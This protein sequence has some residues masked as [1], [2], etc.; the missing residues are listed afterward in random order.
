[1]AVT[2]E[3]ISEY[4]AANPGLSDAEI[5]AAMAQHSVTPEQMAQVTG[6]GQDVVQARYDAATAPLSQIANT[7]GMGAQG[8]GLNLSGQSLA[9]D[10]GSLA[11]TAGM[12]IE[13]LYRTYAGRE[14]DPEGLAY[15]TKD[16]G[17]T[18]D[19][20]EIN[21]FQT[22]VAE[23]RAQGTEPAAGALTQADSAAVR[24]GDA[25]YYGDA[26]TS[27]AANSNIDLSSAAGSNQTVGLGALP[28]AVSGV[29]R[30]QVLAAYANNPLAELNPSEEAINYWLGQG[31]GSFDSTVDA[32]RAADPGLAAAIDASRA[33]SI[34]TGST[35]GTTADTTGSVGALTQV[36]GTDLTADAGSVFDTDTTAITDTTGTAATTGTT[37]STGLNNTHVIA[38]GDSTTFGYNA[39]NQLDT[40]MVSS[41]QTA[42]GNNYTIDNFGVNSTTV[43][44]L[45]TGENGTGSNWVNTLASDAG[46]VVLNYGMNEAYRGE[47]PATFAANLT[48]AVNDLKAAGKTVILQT[49]NIATGYDWAGNVSAYADVIRNVA[50][51]TGSAIDDKYATTSGMGDIFDSATGDTIHP[52]STAYAAL[53]E[54]LANVISG[55]NKTNTDSIDLGGII[56]AGDSFLSGDKAINDI[57]NQT[58][59]VVTNTAIGGQT[60]SDVLNQL[61]AFNS[62]GGTFAPGATVV[63]NVGGNDLLGGIDA[64]TV[65]NNINEIVSRLDA[66]GV[67]VV[68]S[69]APNVG[70]VADLTGSTNLA[71]SDIYNNIANSNSNVTLVDSMSGLLNQKNLV[72]ETGFHLTAP[73]QAGFNTSLSNAY[74]Q[75][76]GASPISF[77]DQNIID[78]VRDNNLTAD[79]AMAMAPSFS[80]DPARV[81]QL[82]AAS[83]A[84]DSDS[85]NLGGNT[86]EIANLY[87]EVL[88]RAPSA[89]EIENWYQQVG[90]N[91]SSDERT[92]F[93]TSAQAELNSRIEGLYE[94][95]LGRDADAE[96]L[97]YW[98]KQFG[99]EIDDAE[100]EQFRQSAAAE[101]IGTFGGETPDDAGLL[102]G[103]KRA[104][105]LGI[106]DDVLKSTLGEDL[107]NTYQQSLTDFAVS[108]LTD[109]V[110]D[111]QLT[112]TEA[113]RIHNFG[114]DL[115]F[116]PE[117]LAEMTG[118]D[119]SIFELAET[120]YK[121]GRDQIINGTLTSDSVT[122]DAD[123]VI[124]SIALQNEYGFTDEEFSEATG[125]DLNVIKSALDPVRSF[126]TDFT[127]LFQNT[128][129]KTADARTFLE[130][131]RGNAAI[132][133]L[134]GDSLNEVESNIKNLEQKWSSYGTDALQAET[135]SRQLNAQRDALGGD[136]Y[137]GIFGDLEK[138]AALLVNKGLDTLNDLGQKDK[139]ETTKAD[140]V[141]TTA[142]GR[143]AQNIDGRFF[144]TEEYGESTQYREVPA[145]Q[146][147]ATYGRNE[148]VQEGDGGY[149]QFIPLTAEEQ[150]SLGEDGTY[151]KKLGTVVID[152]DTGQE[153]TGLDGNLLYQ[154][155]GGH[156][157]GR[158]HY[159]TA[160]FTAE[161]NPILTASEEKSGI[162]GF[163]SDMAPMVLTVASFI[164]G[165]HQPFARLANAALALEQ[166]NYIGAVLS[167][168]SAYGT[169]T[170]NELAILQAAEAS[171]DVVNASQVLELQDTL[172]NIKL[173][174]TFAQGA[175]ALNANNIPGLINSGISAYAQLGGSTLPSGVTTAVQLGNLG[176]ALSNNQLDVAL[177]SLGDLTGSN[178]FKIAGAA[179]TLV[180]AIQRAGDTGDFSGVISAGIG[181]SDV[182]RAGPSTTQDNGGITNRVV[183][184]AVSTVSTDNAAIDAFTAAKN[185]GATD[186]EAMDAANA[187]TGTSTTNLSTAANTAGDGV[188]INNIP[189][190][191]SGNVVTTTYDSSAADNEFGD[192]QGAINSVDNEFGNL[193]GAIETNAINDAVRADELNVISNLPKFSDAY[194]QART[195]LGPNKTFT[196]NGKEYSTAT[197]SERPDLNI[198]SADLAIDVLNAT[199]LATDTDASRTVGAQT[200]TI[201][202]IYG[203]AGDQSAAETARL[204][205]LNEGLA[206][207][208]TQSQVDAA[209][210]AINSV[211]G[212]GFASDLV[213]QGLSNLHQIV[214][215][216]LEFTGG[217][218]SGLGLAGPNNTLTQAGKA[219]NEAGEGLQIEAINEANSNVINAVNNA[220]GFG[221]KLYEGAK[222][223]LENPLSANMAV[224]EIG[225]E[226]LPI[227]VAAKIY[228]LA[229]KYAAV[230]V[231][232][233]L[234]AIESGGSAYNE[235]YEK[236]I[237]NGLSPE[238]ADRNATKAFFIASAVTT[239]T[240]GI[241]D[242]ALVNKITRYIDDSA[243]KVATR[244]V[245]SGAVS[246]AKEAPV[247]MAEVFATGVLTALAR[248]EAPD[249]NKILTQTVVEGY[250]GGKTAGSIDA[251]TS[252]VDVMSGDVSNA[253]N[254]AA[255]STGAATDL[256][257][258]GATVPGAAVVQ[259]TDLGSIGSVTPGA[260]AVV[261][262]ASTLG[263]AG[264]ATISVAD[265]EQTMS[266]LGLNVSG[267]AAVSL[268]TNIQNATNNAGVAGSVAGPATD[269]SNIITTQIG[270]GADAG[271]VIGNTVT[272]AVNSGANLGSVINSS[273][274]SSINAGANASTAIGST[275]TAAVNA[276]ANVDVSVAAAVS[277]AVNSGVSINSVVSAA[278]N[279]ATTTGNNVSVS[280]AANVV[281]ISN[282]TTNTTTTVNTTTGVAT[283][284]DNANNVTTVV[285]GNTTSVVNANTNTTSQ[286][287]VDPNNNTET[288]VTVD[289][290]TN[291][292]TQTV[293]NNNTNVTTST[294]VDSNS[295][296]QTTIDTNNNTQTT[297]LTNIDG[298]TQT[299]VKINIDTGDVI[300][301]KE[302]EIPTNWKPPV[303]ELP[304][305]PGITTGT[306]EKPA[307]PK[308]PK[309]NSL[310]DERGSSGTFGLPSGI[311][312]DPASLRSKVTGG[313]IDPLA[314]VKQA[315]AEL[316]REVMMNQLDPRFAAVIQQRT[317][318]QQQAQQYDKD[319]GAL[320]KLLSGE[321]S[322]PAN[323]GNY[324]SYGSEDSID[325]ILGGRAANYKEGGFVEPLK[326]SG[327]MVLPLLAKSGGALGK[328]S[329]RE[330]FKGGKHV[331]GDGDGQ[332]DDIPAWLADGEFVFPADVVSALGNG[333]TKAGTDKL[334][335]MMHGIRDRARSKG[336]K[337]L[338]PPALKSPLDYLK[339]S[340][341]SK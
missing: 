244:P 179:A 50:S 53:G 228:G 38:L 281:T 310:N 49:P 278:T 285:D 275:I 24:G 178:D 3:Q 314:R 73:G 171:G 183:D 315:Q 181:L 334:Y 301:I 248:G 220:E 13:D 159:L 45:L 283:S 247:E 156:L 68:L 326:A 201:A 63:L 265:A 150:A 182:I 262:G 32:V 151:Q 22:A 109:I 330:D 143:P 101:L 120:N 105:D 157:T 17:D 35:V 257:T 28:S 169:F 60:S 299:T 117:E 97:E 209:K 290:S 33:A 8:I 131:A 195:L 277:A 167:G 192:L 313:A 113:Q 112:W 269:I 328:Y 98:K 213:T 219:I 130:S 26:D 25:D 206:A 272:S 125:V 324:Y 340:K 193:Q 260:D 83:A 320:A 15:W 58:G 69:A 202:R 282:A 135:L 255:T 194:S 155:S 165:P 34:D 88:G 198:T 231:D 43:G 94:A 276:G 249:L 14:P 329:G 253:A 106:S 232:V 297:V 139:F 341:R 298:N 21:I 207:N 204:N 235:S 31:L 65:Q 6:L 196:W 87:Q 134:Y 72:D 41:A 336:P 85:I 110:A 266:D 327:G 242:M 36:A 5:A 149:T 48:K 189:D 77:S 180:D 289:A 186:Q 104:K 323:E 18:I 10:Y 238:E 146:V 93:E 76:I 307:V 218:A 212:D 128:D 177:N 273:I 89:T 216:T 56:L 250:V 51:A 90:E 7:P 170:G 205:T 141:Y 75:S 239:V 95:F 116:T 153:L 292:N 124:S 185:A 221:E 322:A 254:T 154:R 251:T 44:D 214:G 227:G 66:Q 164:P 103:F 222:A 55:L 199:N 79:Q 305:I 100:R 241:T 119:K 311:N 173:A 295:T 57:A 240:G 236:D 133:K 16:F 306:E 123:R 321:P 271:V 1:M 217:A 288:T 274:A 147:N 46:V 84:A 64:A 115:G 333:S 210:A 331:A 325:S 215:Q 309:L 81:Q 264:A 99:T 47:D 237:E 82:L 140:A 145:D 96:G 319:I 108:N 111:N 114:R 70:S 78:F 4:L 200:D 121:T 107:Y 233:G 132:N 27:V 29:T 62:N 61:T 71:M 252:A 126:E 287:T 172:S 168:L 152:K 296:T 286:T 338:P 211:L 67:N 332:S 137:G 9:L 102:A 129:T 302:A 291:T 91:V 138:S 162:Y 317:D 279:A 308:L 243:A 246:A 203:S 127:G 223:I 318:P 267:N 54:N 148:Y 39:G 284:V 229:G 188:V 52:S 234:N 80:V 160:K 312:V 197:A 335:A 191:E 224:I 208:A 86:T 304:N 261:G 303:V 256:G 12:T 226:F 187:V 166:K 20:N 268:A 175:A 176:I 144:V 11:S 19:P 190:S 74:L 40:N 23:A 294:T 300:E 225:Q 161:G 245:S 259:G 339:S 184:D 158:K 258:V 337:D 270:S 174:Q 263:N 37:D 59:Q 163:V 136:Y 293:V 2:N 92:A 280:T 230:G 316:E 118:Q 142:D 122:T 30:D 42:L